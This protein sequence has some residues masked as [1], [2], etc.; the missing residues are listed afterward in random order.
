MKPPSLELPDDQ[1]VHRAIRGDNGAFGQLYERYLELIYRYIYFRVADSYEAE[2]LTETVFLKAWEAL[3]RLREKNLNFKAWLYRV[4]HNVVVDRHRMHKPTVSLDQV[5]LHKSFIGE[6]PEITAQD[7]ETAT[8]IA[9]L[10]ASLDEDLQ[11]VITCRFIMNMSH[12]ETAVI[13]G[14]SEGYVRVL[15]HRALKKLKEILK[16]ETLNE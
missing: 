7:G 12:A 2:D 6:N 1:L 15:Q 3:P 9:R 4:A 8:E 5:V 14:R 13:L 11:Q 10:I 16:D